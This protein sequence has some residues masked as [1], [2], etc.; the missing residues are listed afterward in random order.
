M[1]DELAGLEASI[2]NE[3]CRD[4]LIIWKN[5]GAMVSKDGD[6]QERIVHL[7]FCHLYT[8]PLKQLMLHTE[9]L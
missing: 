7:T 8:F 5:N 3:G 9:F 4:A 6:Q 1:S 2:L